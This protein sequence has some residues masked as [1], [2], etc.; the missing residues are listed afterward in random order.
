MV[1]LIRIFDV[2][3]VICIILFN[4]GRLAVTTIVAFSR[5]QAVDAPAEQAIRR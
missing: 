2:F 5:L 4:P 1:N 3:V